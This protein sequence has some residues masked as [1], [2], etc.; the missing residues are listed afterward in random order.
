VV[1]KE[2][3]E[4]R[5]NYAE[6]LVEAIAIYKKTSIRGRENAMEKDTERRGRA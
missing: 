5:R 2:E 4:K 6:R 1:P 3:E